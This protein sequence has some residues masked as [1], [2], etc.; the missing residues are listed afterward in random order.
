MIHAR[1]DIYCELTILH[2]LEFVELEVISED[3]VGADSVVIFLSIQ[4][5]EGSLLVVEDLVA[6]GLS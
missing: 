2:V 6:P 4:V 1:R 5:F 3:L